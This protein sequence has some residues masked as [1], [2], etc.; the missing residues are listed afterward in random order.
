MTASTH[1][2]PF[3]KLRVAQGFTFL[4]GEVPLR[5]DGSVP[6]GIAAQTEL[7]LARITTTLASAGLDLNDVVQVTAHLTDAADFATFNE[8]YGRHFAE[9]F[10]VRTT[11]LAQLVV[12]EARV[13]VTVVAAKRG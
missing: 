7:V 10:P 11:V 12:P 6:E 1:R 5:E 2:L 8:V 3:S 9:P 4:S 13:E